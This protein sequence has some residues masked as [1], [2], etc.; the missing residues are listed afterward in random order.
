MSTSIIPNAVPNMTR[1]E[2]QRANRVAAFRWG[3][4]VVAFLGGQV[5]IGIAALVLASSDPSVAV[6]P[7]Y[8]QKAVLWDKS[9]ELRENSREMGWSVQHHAKRLSNGHRLTWT[10]RDKDGI[11]LQNVRGSVLLYHHAHARDA[12]TVEIQ[13]LRDGIELRPA[14]LW[15]VELTLTQGDS[16]KQFF[17][18]QLVDL[19]RVE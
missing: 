9:V 16:T 15:Q 8:H 18:S 3:S 1:Q 11:E 7:G 4:L 2:L 13:N 5:A 19:K 14:G 6:V 12:K 10:I 17:D